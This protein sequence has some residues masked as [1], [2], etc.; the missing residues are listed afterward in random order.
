[1]L[2]G[3]QKLARNVVV[4]SRLLGSGS[5]ATL[6]DKWEDEL[7]V[8]EQKSSHLSHPLRAIANVSPLGI[9][10]TELLI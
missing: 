8:G 3:N 2:V 7:I 9:L 5:R 6:A 4:G 1:M 10:R